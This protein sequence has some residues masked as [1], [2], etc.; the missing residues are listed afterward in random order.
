MKQYIRLISIQ[1]STEELTTVTELVYVNHLC[2]LIIQLVAISSTMLASSV[3]LNTRWSIWTSERGQY[4]SSLR[5]GLSR[6]A[7]WGNW[8]VFCSALSQIPTWRPGSLVAW[9]CCAGLRSRHIV[10]LLCTKITTSVLCRRT[11]FSLTHPISHLERND[12]DKL[13][14]PAGWEGENDIGN[15]H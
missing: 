13:I 6:F 9:V 1:I 14:Q 5:H 11:Y 7:S 2:N 10:E 15:C 8:R 12:T 3:D 4:I